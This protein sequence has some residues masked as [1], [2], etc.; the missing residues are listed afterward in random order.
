[1]EERAQVLAQHVGVHHV[2]LAHR[3]GGER[4]GGRALNKDRAVAAPLHDGD[5]SRLDVQTDDV[6]SKATTEA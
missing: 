2:S 4:H 1:M 3:V 6:A 5:E